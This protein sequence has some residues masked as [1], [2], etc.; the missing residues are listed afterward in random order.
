MWGF[1]C[2]FALNGNNLKL[3]LNKI[4]F[5]TSLHTLVLGTC[6]GETGK[7]EINEDD[8]G[9]RGTNWK[10]EGRNWFTKQS[11]HV[12]SYMVLYKEGI[13]GSAF[14]VLCFRHHPLGKVR[15][16]LSVGFFCICVI[17]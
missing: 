15:R 13:K 11:K 3:S 7:H 16:E 14:S 4:T 1:V 12:L 2:L 10:A 9:Q 6:K 5:Q 8:P 17:F